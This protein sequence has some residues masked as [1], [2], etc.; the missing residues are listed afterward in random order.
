MYSLQAPAKKYRPASVTTVSDISEPSQPDPPTPPAIEKTAEP[1]Q[2]ALLQQVSDAS[3]P[4]GQST[5]VV[6]D[7]VFGNEDDAEVHYKTCS[8]YVQATVYTRLHN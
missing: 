6:E 7:D 4:E 8:W 1:N 5:P 2:E 3:D